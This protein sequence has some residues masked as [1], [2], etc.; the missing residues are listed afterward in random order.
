MMK[1]AT[2]QVTQ[3]AF[4][5]PSPKGNFLLG[6]LIDF[7]KD[8][9]GFMT[10]CYKKYGEITP[11]PFAGAKTILLTKPEHIQQV[12][13]DRETFA[14]A[15]MLKS[16]HALLGQG[17]LTSEGETW[18]RQRRLAQPIFHQKR[19][20]DYGE[21]M[22]EYTQKMARWRNYRH[23]RSDDASDFKYCHENII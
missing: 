3:D 22:V 14:K 17:L 15:K 19:I 21:V 18:F 10:E 4:S 1:L 12:L 7:G 2:P 13:K 8:S 6:N 5:L 16:V 23:S 9:L 11:L 20:N